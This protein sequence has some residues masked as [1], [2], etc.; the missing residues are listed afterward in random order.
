M[1][2]T[3]KLPLLIYCIASRKNLQKNPQDNNPT[4]IIR[5]NNKAQRLKIHVLV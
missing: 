1:K 2:M 5:N 4:T 3:N